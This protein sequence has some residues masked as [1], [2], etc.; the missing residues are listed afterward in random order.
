MNEG[1]DEGKTALMFGSFDGRL[2]VVVIL[3]AADSD[4]DQADDD[5]V[6]PLILSSQNGHQVVMELLLDRGAVLNLA[7]NN[8]CTPLFVSMMRRSCSWTGARA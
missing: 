2:R 7:V 4:V 3:L 8:G 6:T 5:G 1:C